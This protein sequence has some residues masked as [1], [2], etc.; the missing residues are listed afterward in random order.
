MLTDFFETYTLLICT[1]NRDILGGS[2]ASFADDV[3]FQGALTPAMGSE[4]S[5]AGVPAQQLVTVLMH[6]LDVTLTT[7]DYVRREKDGVVFRIT[8]HDMCTP[9]CAA[10]QCAQAPVK[11]LVT[12]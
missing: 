4:T 10:M 11:R 3:A 7:G 2:S 8:G 12:L 9:A 5:L 1:L 6:D